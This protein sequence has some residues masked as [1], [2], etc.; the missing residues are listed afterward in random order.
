MPGDPG[1]LLADLGIGAALGALGASQGIALP[2]M[3]L[4]SFGYDATIAAVHGL[5]HDWFPQGESLTFGDVLITAAG[6]AL[7]WLAVHAIFPARENPVPVGNIQIPVVAAGLATL[8]LPGRIPGR[9][10]HATYRWTR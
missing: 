10:R 3:V 8:A 6:T 2:G 9:L 5:N 4:V 1:N 7:G